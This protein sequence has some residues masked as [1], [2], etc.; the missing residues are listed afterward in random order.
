MQLSPIQCAYFKF[1]PIYFNKAAETTRL[2]YAGKRGIF[3][4]PDLHSSCFA[5][6]CKAI[7]YKGRTRALTRTH[8]HPNN[9]Y[10]VRLKEAMHNN[11]A[12]A[13][14]SQLAWRQRLCSSPFHSQF[15][16]IDYATS[17]ALP[18]LCTRNN[19]HEHRLF[20]TSMTVSRVG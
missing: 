18:H 1:Q 17:H 10:S 19:K 16:T 2:Y 14:K 6:Y 15:V 4:N 8:T 5:W 13:K 20:I 3:K 12:Q 9:S 11:K 7:A